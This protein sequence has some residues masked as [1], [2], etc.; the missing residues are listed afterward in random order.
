MNNISIFPKDETSIFIDPKI[1]FI[2]PDV[3]FNVKYIFYKIYENLNYPYVCFLLENKDNTINFFNSNANN[4][5][6]IKE[7]LEEL[8]TN[9]TSFNIYT[10]KIKY[11]FYIKTNTLYVFCEYDK[12]LSIINYEKNSTFNE[13]ISYDIINNKSIYNL[14]IHDHCVTFFNHNH[15]LLFVKNHDKNIKYPSPITIYKGTKYKYLNDII[16]FGE[17]NYLFKKYYTYSDYNTS[18]SESLNTYIENVDY[19]LVVLTD[20]EFKEVKNSK[21]VIKKNNIYNKNNKLIVKLKKSLFKENSEIKIIDS[22]KFLNTIH[23]KVKTSDIQDEK[24]GDYIYP[25]YEKII[26]TKERM[27]LKYIC[28]IDDL[29]NESELNGN[30]I[31]DY[32]GV[33]YKS[34]KQFYFKYDKKNNFILK[35]T[36]LN[37]MI[38]NE[39][40]NI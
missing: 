10:K 2:E 32:Y 40:L 31:L 13:L 19:K 38:L 25:Y 18:V 8:N 3:T 24:Y 26:D 36:N 27:I 30:D 7:F 16:L 29:L 20:I 9:N 35:T 4:I 34:L 37:N 5:E 23:I 39:Y 33:K 6:N 1:L 11:F 22:N 14:N 12:N 28:F 21:Y 15:Y 17:I